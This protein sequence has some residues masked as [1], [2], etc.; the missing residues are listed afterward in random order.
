MVLRGNKEKKN[1]F[2]KIWS[3]ES[4][5]YSEGKEKNQTIQIRYTKHIRTDCGEVDKT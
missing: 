2:K 1:Q 5:S 4:N 3:E